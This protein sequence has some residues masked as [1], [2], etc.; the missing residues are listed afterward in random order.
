MTDAAD[1]PRTLDTAEDYRQLIENL[2]AGLVV[3]AADTSILLCNATAAELLGLTIEQMT[4]KTAIDPAWCFTA[5]DGQPMP[6]EDYPV[7]RVLATGQPIRNLSVGVHRPLTADQVWVL[8]NAYAITDASGQLS[9]VVVTFI[10]V[11]EQR[12]AE[13]GNR[14]GGRNAA[15]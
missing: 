9:Q 11:T 1:V 3:H 12:R 13:E 8:C 2:H 15:W 14:S 6:L 4:G 5:A 7:N 10:D